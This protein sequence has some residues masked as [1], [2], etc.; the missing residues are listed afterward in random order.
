[1]MNSFV[2]G[3]VQ[4]DRGRSK[5][6]GIYPQVEV[7]ALSS[8]TNCVSIIEQESPALVIMDLLMSDCDAV[9]H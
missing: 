7:T 3:I 9:Q 6:N 1:M 2:F 5:L 4:I 8:G